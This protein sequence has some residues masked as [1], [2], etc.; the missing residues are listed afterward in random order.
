MN[1][2]LAIQLSEHAFVLLTEQALAAGK[3]PAE[4]A[5]SVVENA[6][7]G[8]LS[9]PLDAA[10]ARAE[11]EKCFGTVDLGRPIG[12]ANAAIDADLAREYGTAAGPA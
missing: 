4:L 12:L 2:N 7:S 11:F 1:T 6:Y 3:T 8:G 9:K 10:A 5:A